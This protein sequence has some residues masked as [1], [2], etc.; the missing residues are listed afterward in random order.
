MRSLLTIEF[1][2]TIACPPSKTNQIHKKKITPHIYKKNSIFYICA[3][4]LLK[5]SL[6]KLVWMLI[7]IM[8]MVMV[9]INAYQTSQNKCP[10]VPH[11]ACLKPTSSCI[12]NMCSAYHSQAQK[13]RIFLA[14]SAYLIPDI[15]R[16]TSTLN[17]L[18][19]KCILDQLPICMPTTAASVQ[20]I[21]ISPLNV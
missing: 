21:S 7:K 19:S 12:P 11:L 9:M 1:S 6:N 10:Q 3:R 20:I 5:H 16:V 8:M 17:N 4:D 15:P 18:S 13:L 2:V 14:S